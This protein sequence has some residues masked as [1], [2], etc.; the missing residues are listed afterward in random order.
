MAELTFN[1]GLNEQD[2]TQVQ[3]VECTSG[4]NFEL[5]L[6][7][8]HLRARKPFDLL[9]TATNAGSLNGIIQLIK[10]D[11]TETTLV[12]AGDTV[13]LWN[14]TSTFTSKGAV[15]ATS[16]LRGVTWTLGGY[17]V[18]TDLAKL[19]VV[20]QWD[21]TSLTSLT[22]GLLNPLYAK[23]GVV[24]LNRVW[25]F[26]VKAGTDTPHLMV[27]S[28]FEAPTSYDSSKRAQD[29]SFSTGNEAFYMV[30]PDLQ[31]INGVCVFFNT[32][33]IS[34]VG[35]RLYKLSGVDS[36]DFAW[37]PFYSGSSAIGTETVAS[38]G[39]DVV[40]MRTGGVIESLR[41]TMNFGD[42]ETDDLS[43]WIPTTTSGLTDC[44]TIY[45]QQRQKVYFFAGSNKVLVFFKDLAESG[46][47][48]WS[49][50]KTDHTSSFSATT[51]IYMRQPGGSAYYVY[52]ADSSGRLYQMDGT[53]DGDPSTTNINTQR[54]S[55]LIKTVESA[56]GVRGR[57]D[58]KRKADIDLLMDFEWADDY[59]VN[60]CTV[61]LD[62]P[63]VGDPGGYFGGSSYFGGLF[64]FNSG[65]FYSDRISSK[66]FAAIGR[67]SGFY[68]TLTVQ[69]TQQF[70][71][72]KIRDDTEATSRAAV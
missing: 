37:E 11:N 43:R 33:I 9:G 66:G 15:T 67:G 60:R 1:G 29:S 26:N 30:T 2:D 49:V 70:D 10:A 45:D 18:I 28:A 44:I 32:L 58:Y 23:Y 36:M 6:G 5:A 13:Y 17:S 25:L 55:K 51:A 27:A 16:Q 47:S 41:S 8:T 61:P 50:Y 54:R 35:G 56:R 68:L 46:L 48:P 3:P 53:G 39:N 64:Y 38:I 7:N 52:W 21:G 62:G 59:A 20:K 12:Q 65:F 19:T 71:I 24:Y 31:P 42:V 63:P 57:V 22:T 40:Y 69:S 14:G 4:Y 72:L 34:T